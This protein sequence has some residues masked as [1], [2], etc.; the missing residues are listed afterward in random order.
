MKDYI[1][2]GLVVVIVLLL[3]WKTRKSGTDSPGLAPGGIDPSKLSS[4]AHLPKAASEDCAKK[5]GSDW[6]E[7]IPTMC[8]KD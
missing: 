2:V 6:S 8:K 7:F 1:L 3:I 5:Y 4:G